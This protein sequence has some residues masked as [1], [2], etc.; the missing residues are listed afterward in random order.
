ML[1]KILIVLLV[2]ILCLTQYR[3][4]IGEGSFAQVVQLQKKIENQ[5]IQNEQLKERNRILNAEV[6]ALRNGLDAIEEKA[7]SDMGMIKEGETFFMFTEDNKQ[8]KQ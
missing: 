2:I 6:E 4:W 8:K 5:K 3:L 7:R 1:T